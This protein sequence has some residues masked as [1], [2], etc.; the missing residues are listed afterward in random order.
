MAAALFAAPFPGGGALLVASF[1]AVGSAFW[2]FT[3]GVAS[4]NEQAV[5]KLMASATV[6]SKMFFRGK[7][8]VSPSRNWSW[9]L[10]FV[11]VVEQ[12]K[13]RLE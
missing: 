12:R 13:G 3:A 1:V 5:P 7:F 2:W 10:A 4:K 6:A 9:W 8:T 11:P